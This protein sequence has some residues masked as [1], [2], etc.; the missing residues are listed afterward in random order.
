MSAALVPG[1]V[2]E[3]C[4]ALFEAYGHTVAPVELPDDAPP[5]ICGI[6]GFTGDLRGAAILAMTNSTVKATSPVEGAPGWI[7][8][9]VNQLVGRVKN[10]LLRRGV[11][12]V[13][14]TPVTLRGERLA[15]VGTDEEL[16]LLFR[17]ETGVICLWFDFESSPDLV[18]Q[19][20][21][22]AAVS[23]EGDTMF[24]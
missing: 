13:L 12:I 1:I 4:V 21:V 9:L 16:P 24:F 17:G 6:L 11:E 20:P 23:S 8:E 3:C 7:G 5:Q 22:E 19:A 2:R 15:A 18:W 10:E 14:S